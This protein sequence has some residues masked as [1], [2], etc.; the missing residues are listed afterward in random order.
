MTLVVSVWILSALSL[1]GAAYWLVVAWRVHRDGRNRPGLALGL[2]VEVDHWPSVS[3]IIP[4]HNEEAHA[5]E[6]LRSLLAQDYAG[7][8]EAVFVLDRCTDGTR[9][10][11]ETVHLRHGSHSRLAL[12]IVENHSCPSDWAGKCNAARIGAEA[13]RGE[14]LLFT[15]ADTTF[16]S[17]LTR[18]AVALLLDRSLALLSAL[19]EVSV[20]HSFESV[21]Q[22]VAAIQ[23]MKLYPI[24]RV[25]AA[26]RPRA[27]ANGQF[28]LFT[29]ES[30]NALGGHEAVKDDL[31]EDL[32]FARRMVHGLKRRAGLFVADGLLHVR[33]YESYPQFRE[34]WRRILI[35]ACHRN[36]SRMR[37][38]AVECTVI[39]AGVELVALTS[40]GTGMAGLLWGDPPLG[41]AGVTAGVL[42]LVA[43]KATLMHIYSLIGVGRGWVWSYGAATLVLARILWKGADDLRH[44]RPVRWGGRQY[45]L[46]PQTD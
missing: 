45:V 36:P 37:R 12:R 23:L 3:I 35:E 6:L 38:Y 21:V 42:A 14:L 15:D 16:E 9:Q 30:Y 44:R 39:G 22:P 20:R 13:A 11:L 10:A 26:E 8:L 29:R 17:S 40:I 4:A 5:P 31:L 28:M 1:A 32:A 33:M 19:P 24:A 43:Q 41:I 18:A 46:A 7:S 2:A 25:N 27:F 34:G